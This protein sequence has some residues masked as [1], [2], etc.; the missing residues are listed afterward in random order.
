MPNL[1]HT[2]RSLELLFLF[3]LSGVPLL[4]GQ[5]SNLQ[6]ASQILLAHPPRAGEDSLRKLCFDLLD[7]EFIEDNAQS[8]GDVIHFYNSM[9]SHVK[10]DIKE[11]CTAEAVVYSM[12]NHG[13]IIKMPDLVIGFDLIRGTPYFDDMPQEIINAIDIMLVTHEHTDHFD[14]GVL[15]RIFSAGGTVITPSEMTYGIGIHM[16]AGDSINIEGYTIKAYDGLHNVPVRVYEVISPTGLKIV[17]TGDNQD[18]R[19][20]PYIDKVNILL[21]NCWLHEGNYC[22]AAA[23]YKV[24]EDLEPELMIPGHINEL[25]HTPDMRFGY[26]SCFAVIEMDPPSDMVIMAWGEKFNYHPNSCLPVQKVSHPPVIDG[27]RDPVWSFI[28]E[29]SL[30]RNVLEIPESWNDLYCTFRAA[31]DEEDLYLFISVRDDTLRTDHPDAWNN[32]VIEVFIDGDNSKNDAATGYDENDT[33]MRFEYSGNSWNAPNTEYSWNT[34]NKGYDLELRI[35]A[36]DLK[37]DPSSGQVFGFDLQV[38]DNDEGT[39]NSMIRWWSDNINNYQDP[40]LFGTAL[41]S[42]PMQSAVKEID[43]VP[44]SLII[45]GEYDQSWTGKEWYVANQIIMGEEHMT[46]PL[47]TKILWNALWDEEYLYFMLEIKDD[48]FITDSG[49]DYFQDDCIEFWLDGNNSKDEEIDHQSDFGLQ[50]R[51]HPVTVSEPVR[52]SIG[53]DENADDIIQAAK[54]TG[55]GWRF[56]VAI[57]LEILGTQACDSTLIGFDI[58]YNDDDDGGDRDSKL[59]TYAQFDDSWQHPSEWAVGMLTGSGL[60]EE[61]PEG[62]DN[63]EMSVQLLTLSGKLLLSK[64]LLI[65]DQSQAIS[66]RIPSGLREGLYILDIKTD[67]AC[68]TRLVQKKIP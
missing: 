24:L 1:R 59:K 22:N 34:T 12:Y 45:D 21:L 56:E 7:Q 55:E 13:F 47:D 67:E 48:L 63:P 32:D 33:Q 11:P 43:Y 61:L 54:F 2:I 64:K 19:T 17:H 26:D 20:M 51:Y 8:D 40:S 46:S 42:G 57:P 25:L 50:F 30:S 3:L 41:L 27:I 36:T 5:I 68:Y 38:T 23:M 28:P 52:I 65:R 37:F 62:T 53:P 66:L 49:E 16:A 29:I 31:W 18:P 35:P 15:G 44:N 14:Q 58:D 4:N 9:L 10:H 6:E 60:T 39:Q